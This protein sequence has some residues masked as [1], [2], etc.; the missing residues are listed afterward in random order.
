MFYVI[1][2]TDL[3][4]ASHLLQERL[5]GLSGPEGNHGEDV[6]EYYFYEDGVPSHS[7][8]KMRYKYPMDAYPYELLIQEN[9]MRNR[10]EPEFELKDALPGA[11]EQG[12][13]FDIAIEYA[14]KTEDDFFCKI[15]ARNMSKDRTETIHILPHLWFRNTWTWGYDDTRPRL[16]RVGPACVAGFEKHMGA[17]AFSSIDD[18]GSP[19]E[20]M[21]TE[22]DTN[23]ELLFNGENPSPYVKDGF[24]RHI[25]DEE[26]D[27]I[28]PE[29]TGTKCTAWHQKELGPGEEYVV[30]A[31]LA[32][33]NASKYIAD[34]ASG[35]DSRPDEVSDTNSDF[36]FDAWESTGPINAAASVSTGALHSL[37]GDE[38]SVESDNVPNLSATPSWSRS[39][40][41]TTASQP[42]DARVGTFYS[43][44]D[45]LSLETRHTL[46][47]P[48]AGQTDTA[49]ARLRAQ[50][51]AQE[52]QQGED[53]V[54]G[55]TPSTVP[56]RKRNS[57]SGASADSA[58]AQIVAAGSH[59]QSVGGYATGS[60]EAT[61]HKLHSAIGSDA[62]I[63]GAGEGEDDIPKRTSRRYH[64]SSSSLHG[65]YSQRPASVASMDA[66]SVGSGGK[67]PGRKRNVHREVPWAVPRGTRSMHRDDTIL[68]V[69]PGLLHFD[70]LD[71]SANFEAAESTL[72]LR[73]LE[74]DEFYKVIQVCER[75]IGL[76]NEDGKRA[77]M[78][79][80]S[81]TRLKDAAVE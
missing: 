47:R 48:A 36:N 35:R 75:H 34:D 80:R 59:P 61:H 28:N 71:L 6:K 16:E 5:F 18:A 45:K 66:M 64:A 3:V 15:T 40:A 72:I 77:C 30:W 19:G 68:A 37:A 58:A 53:G 31:R 11:F 23:F 69:V 10:L 25:I 81:A 42:D 52:Q 56:Q 67:S 76:W 29:Q 24:H 4:V 50:I 1:E 54:G 32:V 57:I 39:P 13:Y 26:P 12:H 79:S 41:K 17:I 44:M 21:F 51:A 49:A 63:V 8:M 74:T 55:H 62:K 14:K 20:V 70:N 33:E 38:A 22:N 43:A 60:K 7:Y 27:V 78:C 2:S 46:A 65:T 73:R 9:A